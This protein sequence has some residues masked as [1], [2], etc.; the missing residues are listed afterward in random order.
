MF[1]FGRLKRDLYP[2]VDELAHAIISPSA[3]I[4]QRVAAIT[5]AEVG[6]QAAIVHRVSGCKHGLVFAHH[7]VGVRVDVDQL[8]SAKI[9]G[10]LWKVVI[11]T[12]SSSICS[13]LPLP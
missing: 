10:S 6:E 9:A 8:G 7:L 2:V 3:H 4:D 12:A 11:I 5:A 1:G 13:V